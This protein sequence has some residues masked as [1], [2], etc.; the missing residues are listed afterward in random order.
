V[1]GSQKSGS[2][3]RWKIGGPNAAG[4]DE[5][6]RITELKIDCLI[7]PFRFDNP[8]TATQTQVVFHAEFCPVFSLKM[9]GNWVGGEAR[10]PLD[11]QNVQPHKRGGRFRESG[12]A[13]PDS[14]SY[15]S[16]QLV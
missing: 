12:M 13:D 8:K 11:F 9:T 6:S 4:V 7:A 10:S 15:S 3:A 1:A 2:L 5:R 14:T 16:M